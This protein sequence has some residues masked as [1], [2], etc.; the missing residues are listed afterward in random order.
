[1]TLD[2]RAL[3]AA[4]E[5]LET[6]NEWFAQRERGE[7]TVN[8]EAAMFEQVHNRLGLIDA[9]AAAPPDPRADESAPV[10]YRFRYP[11][12]PDQWHYTHSPR[13]LLHTN[14]E[15]Q[16]LYA[17]PAP[18]E[19][20]V[21]EVTAEEARAELPGT[22]VAQMIMDFWR[23]FDGVYSKNVM[24]SN[25]CAVGPLQAMLG[26]AIKNGILALP[27]SRSIERRRTNPTGASTRSR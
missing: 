17:H 1:M 9:L 11:E 21:V 6:L 4:R 14:K 7:E 10:A 8:S 25:L 19:Q 26:L 5:L 3:A 23:E 2:E 15:A 22:T 24:E 16:A 27:L 12:E 20:P 18:V 13:V